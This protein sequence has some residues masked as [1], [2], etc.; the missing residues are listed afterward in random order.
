M[1]FKA[2][3]P[4]LVSAVCASA[5]VAVAVSSCSSSKEGIPAEEV[6][7]GLSQ[8][9]A[10]ALRELAGG[11]RFA[12]SSTGDVEKFARSFRDGAA[13]HRLC[14]FILAEEGKE[15]RTTAYV[16]FREVKRAPPESEGEA[17]DV[18]SFPGVG[19]RAL[20]YARSAEVYFSCGKGAVVRGRLAYGL[21]TYRD[22]NRIENQM[23]VLQ[24]L[25]H[26]VA[27]ALG[28]PGGGGVA[29]P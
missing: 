4:A 5:L 20:S 29:E 26:R 14:A 28:C 10:N 25:S 11:D 9:A 15:K 7:G 19:L 24:D 21:P 3:S 17:W 1:S 16:T 8:K 18:R 27:E 13:T 12:E 6:C 22:S 23:T 2:N